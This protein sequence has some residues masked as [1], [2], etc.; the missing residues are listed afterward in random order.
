M[1]LSKFV[2]RLL[3]AAASLILATPAQ[4][5]L[6]ASTTTFSFTGNCIDCA[7]AAHTA[8]YDVTGTLV[9]QGENFNLG[10]KVGQSYFVSFSYGGSNLLAPY[11]VTSA[12]VTYFFEA[13]DS[14]ITLRKNMADG[15]ELFFLWTHYNYTQDEN[16]ESIRH[17]VGTWS[18]GFNNMPADYGN[19]GSFQRAP[20]GN[21]VP[22]PASALLFGTALVG[23]WGAK[24]RRS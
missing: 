23:L 21:T 22:E 5:S 1:R 12:D 2:P 13:F 14:S 24:R 11:T 17:D 20:N 7:I 16:G 15:S 6:V 18:T 9:L 19:A 10:Q 3:A 4:A 8:S